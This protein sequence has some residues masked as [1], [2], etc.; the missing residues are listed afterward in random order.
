[1]NLD[2]E[3]ME[4]SRLWASDSVRTFYTLRQ[5]VFNDSTWGIV[6]GQGRHHGREKTKC[7]FTLNYLNCT[8]GKIH[9]HKVLIKTE[10]ITES[11]LVYFWITTLKKN[12]INIKTWCMFFYFLKSLINSNIKKQKKQKYIIRI[13]WPCTI[14]LV[15]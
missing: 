7:C 15:V 1:M 5:V 11:S 2:S 9:I 12:Q 13:C 8:T 14:R 10:E 4:V 6:L 3:E